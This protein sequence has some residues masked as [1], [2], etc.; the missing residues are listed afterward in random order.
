VGVYV[1]KRNPLII[2]TEPPLEP[3]N[4]R[5]YVEKFLNFEGIK[6]ICGGTTGNIVANY[7]G[8]TIEMALSTIRKDLPPIGKLS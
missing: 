8:E 4:D 1:R 2:F 6:V 7:L 3:K 5:V